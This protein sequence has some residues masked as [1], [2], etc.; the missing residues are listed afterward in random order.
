MANIFGVEKP[1]SN[2]EGGVILTGLAFGVPVFVNPTQ[3]QLK[4][5][6]FENAKEPTYE[7]T[8]D[9]EQST[10]IDIWLKVPYRDEEVGISQ[11]VAN[12]TKYKYVAF[13]VWSN[14]RENKYDKGTF[15]VSP[16]SCKNEWW[17]DND[18]TKVKYPKFPPNDPGIKTGVGREREVYQFIDT[19]LSLD[20]TK[21]LYGITTPFTSMLKGNWKEI[22][23]MFKANLTRTDRAPRG[24]KVLLGA[25][26]HEG[27]VYQDVYTAAVLGEGVTNPNAIIRELTRTAGTAYAWNAQDTSTGNNFTFKIYERAQMPKQSIDPS[28]A[29]TISDDLPF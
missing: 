29:N 8:K 22:N 10:K 6:G 18:R 20:V 7:F 11:I 17:P 12:D 9:G 26:E 24:V 27:N 1:V 5:V 25:R 15:M 16:A 21:S 14:Y 2:G 23:D 19:W 3:D 4:S 28:E 13:T